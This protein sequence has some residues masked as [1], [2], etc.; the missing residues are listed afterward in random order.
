[1]LATY[2]YGRVETSEAEAT[3]NWPCTCT[4]EMEAT[5]DIRRKCGYCRE[6]FEMLCTEH[7]A[8]YLAALDAEIR[9]TERKAAA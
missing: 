4:P 9:A 8:Q 5:S 6:E 2:E 7:S 3:D 1:M